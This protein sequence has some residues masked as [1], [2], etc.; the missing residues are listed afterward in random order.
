MVSTKDKIPILLRIGSQKT[1]NIN[2]KKII[3]NPELL[4]LDLLGKKLIID[5]CYGI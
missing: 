1:A 3:I 4:K 2:P 5:F